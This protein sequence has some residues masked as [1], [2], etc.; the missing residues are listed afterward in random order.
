MFKHILF[1]VD[2]SERSEALVPYV[3]SVVRRFNADLSLIHVLHVPAAWYGSM[4]AP[5]PIML[6][7]P[8]M[9]KDGREQLD[10]FFAQE[11][12]FRVTRFV[13][14]GDPA[15]RI[16]DYATHNDVDLIIMPT[17]GLGIFRNMLLGS[18]TSKVLHDAT[19][20]VWT[21]AHADGS[22]VSNSASLRSIVCGVNLTEESVRIIRC[23]SD[24]AR[25]FHA[26]LRLVHAAS[27][28]EISG[29]EHRDTDFRRTLLEW[30]HEHLA[31]LQQQAGTNVDVSV[32]GGSVSTVVAAAVKRHS[33][34]LVVIGRGKAQ[35]IFGSLRS[36]A[37][38]VIR[39]SPCPV[40]SL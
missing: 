6:D 17:H 24:L 11:E 33:A 8:G 2:F 36:N 25:E 12:P 27:A 9:L 31:T 3:A 37:Y 40:L 34:D 10:R 19:C 7:I 23:A 29:S 35:G 38:A 21:A 39:D 22:R 13:E 26:E 28:S 1:P 32:E 30:I 14:Q 5:N 16:I 18:V 4:E 20:A 15:T